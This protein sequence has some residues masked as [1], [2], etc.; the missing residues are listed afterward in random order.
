MARQQQ[1]Q[2]TPKQQVL[3]DLEEAR[4]ALAQHAL[5]AAEEWSPRA[6]IARSMMKHRT[7]WIGGAALAGL[8]L[9]KLLRPGHEPLNRRDNFLASAKNRGLLAMVLSPLVALGRKA[10][11]NHGAEWLE[12]FLHQKLSPN[13]PP[14]NQV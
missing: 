6:V 12:S 1:D 9:L 7:L 11:L 3:Q 4:A 14:T 8:A 5:L 2:L 10:I 13:A